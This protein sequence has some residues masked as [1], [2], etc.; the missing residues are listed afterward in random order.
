LASNVAFDQ[1][2]NLGGF[3]VIIIIL[4]GI[5]NTSGVT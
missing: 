3:I 5:P 2:Q 1:Y 4:V